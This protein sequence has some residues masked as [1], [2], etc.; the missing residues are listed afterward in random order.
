MNENFAYLT[1]QLIS[2]ISHS[3]GV[4]VQS[5]LCPWQV[6]GLS[7]WCASE[8]VQKE[9]H[10]YE[11]TFLCLI[12]IPLPHFFQDKIPQGKEIQGFEWH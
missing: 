12:N 3:K 10:F 8:I 2:D 9:T 4:M 7:F 6:P 11:G 1:V 5:W